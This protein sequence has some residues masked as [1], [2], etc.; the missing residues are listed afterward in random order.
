M[1]DETNA[2]NVFLPHNSMR[3]DTFSFKSLS[4]N[5]TEKYVILIVGKIC[6]KESEKEGI[7][8]RKFKKILLCLNGRKAMEE[9][10][11]K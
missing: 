10:L 2:R 4:L 8:I 5:I 11:L 1:F 6:I 7:I 3:G 9:D